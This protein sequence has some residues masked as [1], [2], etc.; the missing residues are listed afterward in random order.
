MMILYMKKLCN[1][2]FFLFFSFFKVDNAI[3]SGKTNST[4]AGEMCSNVYHKKA[5]IS[6]HNGW[7]NNR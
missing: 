6:E 2:F 3:V 1:G 7:R 4:M 5:A